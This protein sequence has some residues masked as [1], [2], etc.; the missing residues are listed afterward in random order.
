MLVVLDHRAL[1]APPLSET[2]LR[3]LAAPAAPSLRL[4]GPGRAQPRRVV[5]IGNFDGIHRG[6]QELFAQAR[7][8]AAGVAAADVVP[9]AQCAT[10]P[11]AGPAQGQ[12]VALSFWPHP[13]RVLAPAAAPA[14]ITPRQRKRELIAACGV[15]I[16]IEQPFDLRFAGFS[17]QQFVD[18]LLIGSLR[19]DAVCVGY[20]FNFGKAR[21]GNAEL[22][23]ALLGAAGVDVLV[24]PAF[25]VTLTAAAHASAAQ[26]TSLSCS[27][28]AVRRAVQGGRVDEAAQVL[29]RE[30]EVEGIVVPGAARGRTLG[31]PTANLRTEA[32]LQPAVGIYAAWAEILGPPTP[33][34]AAG[35]HIDAAAV[36]MEVQTRP[37][38]ATY[39]AAVSVG[40]NATFTAREGAAW[41]PPVSIEAH[42]IQP[43]GDAWLDLYGQVVRLRLAARL[44]DEQ[45]FS[46]VDALVTQIQRDIADTR[47]ILGVPA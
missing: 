34:S 31:I 39:P 38:L 25:S 30:V 1:P 20:D 33:D 46:S 14:L 5:V 37:V 41:P 17:P 4:A 40:Y 10:L 22:L 8:M 15:D 11:A 9:S 47:A 29:G 6:H 3:P 43:S 19:A 32:D 44:R 24:M 28:S 26:T 21:A 42:L 23:R 13:T 16:L 36:P 18:E 45:K 35:D 27:S 12:V 2:S 7:Q